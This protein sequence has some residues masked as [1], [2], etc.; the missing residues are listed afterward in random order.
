MEPNMKL[1]ITISALLLAT[2][3]IAKHH[4]AFD[5]YNMRH[6]LTI[7]SGPKPTKMAEV[8]KDAV[9]RGKKLYQTHC[10]KCHGA[11][12]KGDG[13]YAVKKGIKPTNFQQN[14][15]FLPNHYLTIQIQHGRND[16]PQWKDL[17][18]PKQTQDLSAY[19]QTFI[20]NKK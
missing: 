4:N 11:D 14:F 5:K 7:F 19:V 1:I 6:G 20:K 3:I 16:M 17:L 8:D 18:S 2:P 9:K 13:A 10:L 12:G 15:S